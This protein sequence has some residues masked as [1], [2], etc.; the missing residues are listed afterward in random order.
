MRE[1]IRAC[2]FIMHILGMYVCMYASI[3]VLFKSTLP[4]P[5]GDHDETSDKIN[6]IT[7]CEK[8]KFS[9]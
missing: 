2:H 6:D 8:N 9:V 1:H 4:D 7:K 5:E 3:F